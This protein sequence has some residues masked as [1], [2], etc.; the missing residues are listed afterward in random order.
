MCVHQS[1][2]IHEMCGRVR[3]E[4]RAVKIMTGRNAASP[5]AEV[6]GEAVILVVL[7]LSLLSHSTSLPSGWPAVTSYHMNSEGRYRHSDLHILGRISFDRRGHV[8]RE[9]WDQRQS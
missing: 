2:Q 3:P 9:L 7:E 6:E 4:A 5:Q 1:A 8:A